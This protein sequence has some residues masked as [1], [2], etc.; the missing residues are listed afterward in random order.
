MRAPKGM[1]TAKCSWCGD[2][3]VFVY[4]DTGRCDNCAGRFQWCS[5]CKEW[6]FEEDHCRHIFDTGYDGWKGSGSLS[7][8]PW[9]RWELRELEP[10]KQALYLLLDEMPAGFAAALRV[11][12]TSG[13][14]H[15]WS[16]LPMIGSGGTLELYGMPERE[17]RWVNI[18]WGDFL[19][20]IG[21]GDFAEETA[22][23]YQWLVSLYNDKTRKA[24][25]ITLRW[26]D[27]YITLERAAR[28]YGRAA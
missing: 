27:S 5:I 10:I 21:H 3:K 13:K 12:I 28:V 23:A 6:Q 16:C 20:E 1:R 14:F 9:K 18:W 22:D 4:K 17:G 19:M 8:G 7:C 2:E 11:A 25:N 24:N 26:L 15:T